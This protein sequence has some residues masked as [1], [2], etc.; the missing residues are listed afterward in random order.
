MDKVII[1]D[2]SDPNTLFWEMLLPEFKLQVFK[3][4]AG[5]EALQLIEAE[6]ISLVITAWDL[7][8]MP[9]ALI[10]QK[11][12]QSGKQR[13]LPFLLYSKQMTPDEIS[14]IAELGR[15]NVINL[16]FDRAKVREILGQIV[17][18]GR[19]P[20]P[21][22]DSLR[23][24]EQLLASGNPED[25]RKLIRP[26]MNTAGPHQARF[27]LLAAEIHLQ[28][29]DTEKAQNAL[30][31][32]LKA[33]PTNILAMY[34]SARILSA[35]G[36]HDEAIEVLNNLATNN[37]KNIK[38]LANL[39]SAHVAADHLA[40]AKE[41]V[42]KID[43]LDSDDTSANHVKGKIA[44]KEGDVDLASKLLGSVEN[45]NELARFYNSVG[46]SLTAKGNYLKAVETYQ[47]AVKVLKNRAKLHLV[48]FNLALAYRKHGDT[49]NEAAYFCESYNADPSFE[50][51]YACIARAVQEAKAKGLT[52]DQTQLRAAGQSRKAFLEKNPSKA[53]VAALKPMKKAQ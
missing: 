11:A 6:N 33:E 5:A 48:F 39:G 49:A 41:V 43:L 2:S 14:L 20:D 12:R 44:L 50:K 24:I 1:I 52:L 10:I 27:Y 35:K 19:A 15:A 18:T 9:G 37:P 28:L 29:G 47:S 26:E 3:A 16:P 32:S 38:T 34:L 22:D 25:A 7:P 4:R 17:T 31:E 30:D 45:G 36:Q 40:E 51:A 53:P 42:H 8:S 13:Y 23:A 46:I 21:L